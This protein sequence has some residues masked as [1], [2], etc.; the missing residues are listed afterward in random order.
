MYKQDMFSFYKTRLL[1]AVRTVNKRYW[2]W[3]DEKSCQLKYYR[4][5][6]AYTKCIHE[7]VGCV[8]HTHT[9]T[10]TKTYT[11]THTSTHVHTHRSIDLRYAKVTPGLPGETAATSAEFYIK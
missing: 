7:P 5:Q 6:E 3:F 10:Y 4:N 11:H 8:T 1:V 2:F 9:R